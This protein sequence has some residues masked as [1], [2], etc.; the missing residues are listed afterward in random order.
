MENTRFITEDVE[1]Y[2]FDSHFDLCLHSGIFMTL[3]LHPV[4]DSPPFRA[5]Y[6]GLR[7]RL[8]V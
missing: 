6:H 2:P 1:R 3:F 7:D 8:G 5:D 4:T